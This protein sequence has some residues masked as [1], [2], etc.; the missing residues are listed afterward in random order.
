MAR[1]CSAEPHLDQL[2]QHVDAVLDPTVERL[3][4]LGVV[5]LASKS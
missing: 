4:L 2:R 1:G 5:H 3:G